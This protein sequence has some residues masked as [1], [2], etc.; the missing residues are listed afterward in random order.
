MLPG[1]PSIRRRL[2]SSRSRCNVVGELAKRT[3]SFGVASHSLH[4]VNIMAH[5]TANTRLERI[6]S[7]H[8]RKM[9]RALF[10]SLLLIQAQVDARQRPSR[11][12]RD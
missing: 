2:E 4:D 1:G 3:S 10:E 9:R 7:V 11:D 8:S 12:P 5:G 6:R